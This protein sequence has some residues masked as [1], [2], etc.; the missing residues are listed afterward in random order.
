MDGI[1]ARKRLNNHSAPFF[2][3]KTG[4]NRAK[5]AKKARS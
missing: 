4:L 5:V 1:S 2:S 3:P